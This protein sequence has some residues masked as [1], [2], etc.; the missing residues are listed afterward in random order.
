MNSRVIYT[1]VFLL[2]SGLANSADFYKSMNFEGIDKYRWQTYTDPYSGNGSMIYDQG[3]AYTFDGTNSGAIVAYIG[4][5]T[6]RQD[7][8]VGSNPQQHT[9]GCWGYYWAYGTN[10]FMQVV[11]TDSW[12]PLGPHMY[13][14]S[15]WN[16][17][18]PGVGSFDPARN[19]TMR[20]IVV[21]GN[22][23]ALTFIDSVWMQCTS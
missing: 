14:S 17:W 3:G 15:N 8:Y 11:D 4:G 13:H 22:T 12:A 6:I 21:A 2:A 9:N 7:T 1:I 16:S 18:Q 10:G 5:A 20:Y 23:T 19:V